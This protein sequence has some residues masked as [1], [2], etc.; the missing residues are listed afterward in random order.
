MVMQGWRTGEKA[1]NY[2]G[3]EISEFICTLTAASTS[4]SR[5]TDCSTIRGMP[6]PF[7]SMPVL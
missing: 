1:M 4:G 2:I 7:V 5:M 3:F 6:T